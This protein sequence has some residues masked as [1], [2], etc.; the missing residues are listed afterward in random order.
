MAHHG[1]EN[2][3]DEE[4]RRAVDEW[5][6]DAQATPEVPPSTRTRTAHGRSLQEALLTATSLTSRSTD[7][8]FPRSESPRGS[9]T[10][11]ADGHGAVGNSASSTAPEGATSPTDALESTLRDIPDDGSLWMDSR[12]LRTTTVIPLVGE[13]EL[14]ADADDF[15]AQMHTD[16]RYSDFLGEDYATMGLEVVAATQYAASPNTHARPPR[17]HATL[18]RRSGLAEHARAA[19]T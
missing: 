4:L 13:D 6:A 15:L 12:S 16:P 10:P 7:L 17:E 5:S 18:I 14:N 1:H 9:A 19:A 8:G 3:S 2:V 11:P